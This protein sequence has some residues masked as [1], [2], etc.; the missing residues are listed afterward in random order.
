MLYMHIPM[1]VTNKYNLFY[2]KSMLKFSIDLTEKSYIIE[3]IV[4]LLMT[5]RGCI[6]G[7]LFMCITAFGLT[8]NHKVMK[9]L[10]NQ[11]GFMLFCS[12]RASEV[13]GT[14][15]PNRRQHPKRRTA[16]L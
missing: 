15:N 1:Y 7:Q 8:L 4:S 6:G 5:Q 9:S 2:N 10:Q 13:V 3:C 11:P 12:D 16:H 14:G